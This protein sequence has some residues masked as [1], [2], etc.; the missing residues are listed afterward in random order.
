MVFQRKIS[1]VTVGK[2]SYIF[3]GFSYI[4]HH[5]VSFM[6]RKEHSTWT[7]S[8]ETTMIF[9]KGMCGASYVSAICGFWM[10][11]VPKIGCCSFVHLWR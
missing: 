6:G 5:F 2:D 10:A 8:Y 7:V 4:E 3:T 1:D 11:N 9:Y